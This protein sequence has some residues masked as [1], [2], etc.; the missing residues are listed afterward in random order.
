MIYFIL[1]LFFEVMIS[2]QVGSYLG[3]VG[4]FL[5][6]MASGLV[7][8]IL[9]LNVKTTMVQSLEAMSN[10]CINM[11]QFQELNIFALL[12]AI[13]L[14]LPG[15]LSDVIGVFMQFSVFTGL[16]ISRYNKSKGECHNFNQNKGNENVIDV[17][18]IS[19]DTHL[20]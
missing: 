14:I 13:F 20:K 17:E 8:V 12:G 6:I 5:E 1:Y 18:V 16:L 4:T 3:G 15:I 10:N 9:L 11:K 7:G 19:N 2:V